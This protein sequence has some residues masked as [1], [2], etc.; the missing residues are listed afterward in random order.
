M[1]KSGLFYTLAAGLLLS[2]CTNETITE[3]GNSHEDIRT[4]VEPTNTIVNSELTERERAILHTLSDESLVFDFNVDSDYTEARVW[5][6]K[7]EYGELAEYNVGDISM[8]ISETGYIVFGSSDFYDT[9]NEILFYIGLSSNLTSASG[10]IPDTVSSD[11]SDTSEIDD[12]EV[13]TGIIWEN[14][15][16]S[17][18]IDLSDGEI[19]LGSLI[20]ANMDDGISS[21]TRDFYADVEGNIEQIE[22]YEGVYLF[23]AEFIT[24]DQESQD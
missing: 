16:S 17:D 2:A 12:D 8:E 9:Q 13:S 24:A 22:E 7:Y 19:I 15:A 10:T 20:Y 11:E 21:L 3:N 18:E 5:I 4:E 1:K 23:K 6:E 14:T